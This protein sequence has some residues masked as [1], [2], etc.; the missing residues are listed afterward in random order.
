MKLIDAAKSLKGKPA[1]IPDATRDELPSFFKEMGFK[2]GA[3]IGTYKGEFTKEFCKTGL[4]IATIDPWNAYDEANQE[5]QNLIFKSAIELL[6]PYKN[7]RIIKK[8]SMEAVKGFA[9]ESLDFVYIDGNHEFRFIA[10]DLAEW[11]KKV[12]PGGV[13]SGD[14]YFYTK[15]T[16]GPQLWHVG[17]VLDA[18]INAYG[19]DNWYVIGRKFA[20]PGEKRDKWRSWFFIK[21]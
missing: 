7:C 5:R 13:V 18:Y 14:D 9:D 16:K 17:Y 19:I 21:K 4:E 10:E 8:T 15:T 20:K 12:R 6:T 11:T 3:E 2:F 1:E